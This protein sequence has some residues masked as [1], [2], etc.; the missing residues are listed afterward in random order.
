MLSRSLLVNM[1]VA[2]LH[3]SRVWRLVVLLILLFWPAAG[4]PSPV[5]ADPAAPAD[6]PPTP[7]VSDGFQRWTIGGGLVYWTFDCVREI[8]DGFLKGTPALGGTTALLVSVPAGACATHFLN[9][10]ADDS[11]I[12]Y[13]NPRSGWIEKRPISVPFG[14]AQPLFQTS[15]STALVL[16]ATH[17]YFSAGGSSVVA[18]DKAGTRA[19]VLG[20]GIAANSLAVDDT[21]LYWLGSG[22]LQRNRKADCGGIGWCFNTVEQLAFTNGQHLL[23]QPY[24]SFVRRRFLYWIEGASIK[25][26]GCTYDFPP[27]CGVST[28]Y[29]APTDQAWQ[30]SRL[31]TDGSRL[32]WIENYTVCNPLCFPSNAGVLRRMSLGGG[33]PENI[34]EGLSSDPAS[35]VLV[36]YNW[37]YYEPSWAHDKIERLPTNAEAIRH[38]LVAEAWEVTQSIQNLRNQAPL[39]A[40][41]PTYV[42]LY[43]RQ[44][45]GSRVNAVTAYLEGTT[46]G[47]DPLPGSPLRSINGERALVTGVGYDRARRNDGWLFELPPAWT[48]AGTI[49]LRARLDPEGRYTDP[50]R[51]NNS[52]PD[53]SQPAARLTFNINRPVCVVW[54]PVRTHSAAASADLPNFWQMINRFKT[55]WPVSDVWVYQQADD[56]AEFQLRFGIPPWEYG[57]YE[58]PED[59]GKIILS[60]I[61]R[62]AFADDPDECDDAGARTHYFGMV[63]P[64]A[65]TGSNS[66]YANYAIAVGWVKLPPDTPDGVATEWTK[67]RAGSTMA[68]ELGHNYNGLFGDRWKHVNCGGPEGI[69]PNYPGDPC[70]L[71]SNPLTD[72]GTYF[73]FDVLTQTPIQPDAAADYMSY[74]PRRWVS[75]YNWSGMLNEMRLWPGSQDTAFARN[76]SG[77]DLG[78]A[79]TVVMASGVVTPASNLGSLSYAWVFRTASMSQGILRKWQALAVPAFSTSQS[80]LSATEEQAY[81]LRLLD[82]NHTVLDDRSLAPAGNI[83]HAGEATTAP[84]VVTFPAPAGAVAQLDLMDG[85]TVLASLRPGPSAPDLTLLQP[86]GGQVVG[87]QMTISWRASD[88][89]PN[90]RLLYTVQYSPDL[91]RTWRAL[92]TGIPGALGSDTTTLNLTQLSGLP[93]STTGALIRVAASDGYHTTITTSQPFALTDRPPQPHIDAPTPGQVIAAGQV[94]ILSG[95]ATDAEDG[96]LAGG[97]L[98]WALNGNPLGTGASQRVDGLAPGPYTV[99]LAA[100]D[101]ANQTR[102]VTTTLKVGL[103]AIPPGSSEP[104]LDGLCDDDAYA[105]SSVVRLAPYSNGD[106]A[107]VQLMRTNTDLWVCFNGL[108]KTGGGPGDFVV[109]RADVDNSRHSL[110]QPTDYEFWLH[111]NGTP[112]NVAGNGAGGYANPGPGGMAGRVSA[113]PARWSAEMRISASVLGGWNHLMG[114]S[115]THAWVNAFA[116][117]Y[118]WPYST[119]WNRPDT[120]APTVL[121][122]WPQITAVDPAAASAGSPTFTLTVTGTNFAPGA[123]LRWDGTP[124]A[125]NRL[126]STELQATVDAA[127]M[128]A[129]RIAALTVTNPGLEDAPSN[130]VNFVVNN[131]VPVLTSLTPDRI[132]VGADAFDLIVN[133]AN[134]VDGATVFWNGIALPTVFLQPTQLRATVSGARHGIPSVVGIAVTNPG[135]GG[136]GSNTLVFHVSSHQVFLPG[137][138]R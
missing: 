70:K 98:S 131:P 42:R 119:V 106:Q 134:F 18:V 127:R 23:Y 138:V 132:V 21:Y 65:G 19:F 107:G 27:A 7:V 86:T 35:P 14:P 102:T 94:A 20:N 63:H 74:G 122:D 60:L 22:V 45:V 85:D 103:L 3:G 100:R 2:A 49:A 17:V 135:P 28:L 44:L 29:T 99:A 91:G 90:D 41:K 110:A 11:G 4:R 77:A 96:M 117:D 126:S 61:E 112:N 24:N 115:F 15:A 76:T 87:D 58:I 51:S 56:I 55:L 57:P 71:D 75:P 97:A 128:A 10:A 78:A 26:Y 92:L 83:E 31:G 36:A 104:V 53:A 88:A 105:A 101:S 32:F 33:T 93:G 80:A 1:L 137:V 8:R 79:S 123:V 54:V 50:N 38:D 47:G 25:S 120:W 39:V 73:G 46:T 34:A 125:T 66:G 37:V 72:P 108:H 114:T 30:L 64:T 6:T 12:Y 113:D 40:N 116:D 9:P 67:P 121:G 68:Q 48:T 13:Y 59:N 81:H 111:E 69:N 130:A 5:A 52:L 136:G 109:V 95:G 16:D 62:G 43:G 89:D 124:L 129:S 133:G 82:P 118:Q 84:F